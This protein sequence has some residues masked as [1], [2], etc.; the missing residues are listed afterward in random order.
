VEIIRASESWVLDLKVRR[1]SESSIDTY[2]L[3]VRQFADWCKQLDVVGIEEVTRHHVRGF[4]TEMVETRSALPDVYVIHPRGLQYVE[5]ASR[6]VT[7][8]DL[9]GAS[10]A[11]FRTNIDLV[12]QTPRPERV[13]TEA[14]VEAADSQDASTVPLIIGG[15]YDVAGGPISQ[16]IQE[17]KNAPP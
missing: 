5:G 12:D 7:A 8:H 4:I 13:S 2:L 14:V 6:L 17:S 9:P 10:N 3:A 15:R 1:V 16:L 11:C